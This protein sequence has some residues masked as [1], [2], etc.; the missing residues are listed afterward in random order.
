VLR[1]GRGDVQG[2]VSLLA[3]LERTTN[4]RDSPAFASS[5]PEAVRTALAAGDPD[6]AARLADGLEPI[7]P[8]YDYALTTARA[9]LAEHRGSPDEAAELFAD[10]AERWERFEMPWE[11]AQA[12][13]GRVRCFL[14][15]GRPG[16]AS[17]PLRT[18]REIF[19]SLGAKPALAETDSMLASTSERIS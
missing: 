6:L 2:A 9:L 10:A 16:E 7:Y 14:E 4:V 15:L 1:L 13:L 3:E 19:S 5:L 12:L 8:L 17:E 11:Q 18:A